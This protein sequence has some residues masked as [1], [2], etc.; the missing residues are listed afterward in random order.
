MTEL[1]IILFSVDTRQDVRGHWKYIYSSLLSVD[2]AY[3]RVAAGELLCLSLQIM[4]ERQCL[5]QRCSSTS[6]LQQEKLQCVTDIKLYCHVWSI[7]QLYSIS[8]AFPD[9]YCHNR[10]V[11]S[12]INSLFASY[13]CR[14]FGVES[15]DRVSSGVSPSVHLYPPMPA[16][17]SLPGVWVPGCLVLMCFTSLPYLGNLQ[18]W[19]LGRLT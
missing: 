17:Y 9:Q 2:F 6:Q 16:L 14:S 13:P 5:P 18:S 7:M 1:P 10:T 19:C 11:T 12:S 15:G 4:S 3:C 8:T